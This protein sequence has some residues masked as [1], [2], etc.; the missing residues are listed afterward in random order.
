M[1][2]DMMGYGSVPTGSVLPSDRVLLEKR[3][4]GPVKRLMLGLDGNYHARL[5]TV[6]TQTEVLEER[7]SNQTK[8]VLPNDLHASD[9]AA[10][11]V[12]QM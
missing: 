10:A 4:F 8:G 6:A 12:E 3:V 9:S 5:E 11:V 2:F 1:R 7:D